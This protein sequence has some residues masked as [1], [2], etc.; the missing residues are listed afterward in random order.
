MNSNSRELQ[1]LKKAFENKKIP[2]LTLDTRWHALFPDYDKPSQIKGME[3][4]LNQLIRLQGKLTTDIR[5]MKALKKKLMFEIMESMDIDTLATKDK[6]KKKMEQ[7][8]RLIQEA[9]SKIIEYDEELGRLPYLIK[10][11]NENLMVESMQI[12]YDRMHRNAD[13]INELEDWILKTRDELKNKILMKQDAELKNETMY[14]YM[15]D[16]LGPQVMEIFDQRDR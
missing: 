16:L 1:V 15:H 3:E 13:E 14:T 12:C 2:I 5:D 8:R 9:N 6:N 10:E 7:N 4:Q 11:A